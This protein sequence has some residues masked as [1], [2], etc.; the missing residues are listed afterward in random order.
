MAR[1]GPG[2]MSGPDAEPLREAVLL[3]APGLPEEPAESLP[4]GGTCKA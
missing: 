4:A 1:K 3:V 2:A